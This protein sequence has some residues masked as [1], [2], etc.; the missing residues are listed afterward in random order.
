M[1]VDELAR[2]KASLLHTTEAYEH[3]VRLTLHEHSDL[4]KSLGDIYAILSKLQVAFDP[5]L[6]KSEKQDVEATSLLG[7]L[8]YIRF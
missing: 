3:H 7:T 1:I 8:S 4:W 5:L 2:W 6:A